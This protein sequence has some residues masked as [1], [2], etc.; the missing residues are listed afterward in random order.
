M[1]IS[2]DTKILIKLAE[3]GNAAA[4]KILIERGIIARPM[5]A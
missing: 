1:V 4:I 2:M 5:A 3:Q